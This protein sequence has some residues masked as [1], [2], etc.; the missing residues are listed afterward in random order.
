MNVNPIY[1]LAALLAVPVGVGVVRARLQP[2]LPA[3]GQTRAIFGRTR[4]NSSH[5]ERAP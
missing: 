2:L 3:P 5:R 1:V 4:R